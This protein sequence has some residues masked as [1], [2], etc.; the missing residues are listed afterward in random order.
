MKK[1]N[2]H[3][4]QPIFSDDLERA[5]S[6]KEDAIKE[7]LLDTFGTGLVEGSQIS[8]TR[9]L[10]ITINSLDNTKIDIG[11]GVAYDVD[12]ERIYI[13]DSTN[14][15]NAYNN[16]GIYYSSGDPTFLPG[17]LNGPLTQT[18]DGLGGFVL[19]PQIS[20]SKSIP[21]YPSEANYVY[22]KYLGT[23][24]QSI[25]TLQK[26]TNKRLFTKT[27]DG[28]LIIVCANANTSDSPQA[29]LV[30]AGIA[31]PTKYVF[32]GIANR[33]PTT[34]GPITTGNV[35]FSEDE[36]GQNRSDFYTVST[37]VKATTADA[38]G[39]N[40][41][42]VYGPD[43]T[44][45]FEEHIRT[46]GTGTVT[47][48]NPHGFTATDLGLSGKTVPT[49]EQ[50]FHSSGIIGNQVATVSSFNGVPQAA[51]G[52]PGYPTF[53]RDSFRI[54]ALITGEQ[55]HIRSSSTESYTYDKDT[56]NLGSTHEFY[57]ISNTGTPVTNGTYYIVLDALTQTIKLQGPSPDSYI[58]KIGSPSGTYFTRTVEPI[59]GSPPPTDFRLYSMTFTDGTAPG[60]DNF[61]NTTDLRLFG[62]TGS[63]NLLR[64]SATDTVTIDHNVSITKEVLVN[65]TTDNGY[66]IQAGGIIES[67]IGGF[68]FP[69]TTIQT[70]AF[71]L[72]RNIFLAGVYVTQ[73]TSPQAFTITPANFKD[74][75]GNVCP[76]GTLFS[77]V[78]CLTTNE[79][80]TG[81][82]TGMSG[83][84]NYVQMGTPTPGTDPFNF[85]AQSPVVSGIFLNPP[86][87]SQIQL[88]V[89]S[90][91]G[92][93]DAWCYRIIVGIV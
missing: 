58:V 38:I 89:A 39:S 20:G 10:D 64:D 60:F 50:V 78:M 41:T 29:V 25:Y 66:P 8:G 22:I 46:I 32:L 81:G 43:Q 5:Q 69:D 54:Y 73:S 47:P 17:T 82:G 12:G 2:F 13:N 63:D 23:V 28:Y 62:I 24:D 42:T 76:V 11:S 88:V 6:S 26:F 85:T 91:A 40:K 9:V 70:T 55:V 92:T 18:D 33:I 34:V 16:A 21:T 93:P 65:T 75:Y 15:V 37:I 72:A 3:S 90:S 49:H 45:S 74:F 84:Y 87:N 44:V 14:Y 86:N 19:T 80:H 30:A 71:T 36:G 56:T 67:Q 53:G 51:S 4:D 31:D 7:R 35:L 68:R 79:V 48:S 27:D 77:I 57:F 59:P 1:E 61:S 52:A 83:T